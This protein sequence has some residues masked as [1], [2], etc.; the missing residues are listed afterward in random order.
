[1]NKG[2]GVGVRGGSGQGRGESVRS[3]VTKWLPK[4]ASFEAE[5]GSHL[6]NPH[7][8]GVRIRF[9]TEYGVHTVYIDNK[10]SNSICIY[11]S[12]VESLIITP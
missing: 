9:T 2:V 1:M 5:N 12:S 7:C 11:S 8:Y 10:V 6:V 4:K 3:R